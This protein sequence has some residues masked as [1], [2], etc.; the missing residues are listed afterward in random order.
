MS[1][2][3]KTVSILLSVPATHWRYVKGRLTT[4][5]R[6]EQVLVIEDRARG[7]GDKLDGHPLWCLPIEAAEE[8]PS[9]LLD[10]W[11]LACQDYH[12]GLNE[13]KEGTPWQTSEEVS[14]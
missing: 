10:H 5:A 9:G 7:P 6:G 14:A 8:D 2:P 1:E 11:T 3:E 4:N 13:K 12:S